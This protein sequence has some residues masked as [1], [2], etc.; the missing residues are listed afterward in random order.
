M[1]KIIYK[2]PLYFGYSYIS[3]PEGS[4]LLSMQ[5]RREKISLW[6]LVDD[7]VLSE[8][9]YTFYLAMTGEYLPKEVDEYKF[10]DTVQMPDGIVIHVFYT[11]D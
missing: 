8:E 1:N 2:Y 11:K 9:H 7:T 5:N 6:A 3:L 4:R 10:L